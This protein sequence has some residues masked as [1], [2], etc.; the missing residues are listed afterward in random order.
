MPNYCDN[1]LTIYAS[2]ETVAKIRAYVCSNESEFD[3]ANIIPLPAVDSD[4]RLTEEDA[5]RYGVDDLHDWCCEYWGT[6]WN[7]VDVQFSN[8][9]FYF[10]TAWSPACPVIAKLA[11]RFPEA[12]IWFQYEEMGMGFCGVE[13]YQNGE[14]AY[15]MQGDISRNWTLEEPDAVDED[16]LENYLIED[17]MF[18]AQQ[19]GMYVYVDSDRSIYI[20]TYKDGKI[21][22]RIDGSCWDFRQN[23]RKNAYW[24]E[25]TEY[26]FFEEGQL[27]ECA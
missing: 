24:N 17:D 9:N 1:S 13:V 27:E 26:Q 23:G 2:E 12:E 25:T 5:E 4:G 21:Y 6:K 11:E 14:L 15:E 8:S 20:R 18:P 19:N 7:S 16:E 3:F 22:E 10:L